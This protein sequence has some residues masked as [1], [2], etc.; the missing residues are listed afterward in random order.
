MS[1]LPF[2]TTSAN[3]NLTTPK[4]I[5]ISK[6]INSYIINTLAVVLGQS[7][8]IEVYLYDISGSFITFKT[9]IMT[10][11]TY[12]GWTN[13]DLPYVTNWV[14]SQIELLTTL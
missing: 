3:I 5:T 12:A 13:N 7:A 9:F 11:E 4:Q 2:P 6:T 8:S 1:S 10:G 14:E